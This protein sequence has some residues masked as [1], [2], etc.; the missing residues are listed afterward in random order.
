MGT[1]SSTFI[2][3]DQITS[4]V[5]STDSLIKMVPCFSTQAHFWDFKV[6]KEE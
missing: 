6:V 2:G 4:A 1:E 5:Q 3:T